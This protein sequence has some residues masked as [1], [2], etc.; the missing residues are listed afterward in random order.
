MKKMVIKAVIFDMDGLMIDSE[1]VVRKAWKNVG[2]SMGYQEL[3]KE[4]YNCMGMSAEKE[5]EYFKKRFGADFPYREFS[6]A[7]KKEYH[8]YE[9][10]Y[11]IS[12]KSGL[13]EILET[14]RELK[15]PMAVASS[16]PNPV[17]LKHLEK[18][19]AISYFQV[20]I[21]GDMIKETKP[22]PEI[23]LKACEALHVKPGAAVALEDSL[24]G[25][26]SAYAAGMLP[27][28]IP[29]LTKDT[30][31][32]DGMLAAKL[33]NLSEAAEWIKNCKIDE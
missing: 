31:E 26:K 21:S 12:A 17:V 1:S 32:V 33:N 27:V 25:I 20:I 14:I 3:D 2:Q 9:A 16:S 15:I 19:N 24:N 5:E 10:A 11:G 30:K 22:S 7:Y 28:M 29:D 18:H 4:I 8:Q 13:H 6:A 23:Y